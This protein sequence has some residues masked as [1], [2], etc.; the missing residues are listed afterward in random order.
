MY[1]FMQMMLVV[2]CI[3]VLIPFPVVAVSYLA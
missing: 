3:A 2:L 1:V